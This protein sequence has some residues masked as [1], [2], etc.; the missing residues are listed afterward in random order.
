MDIQQLLNLKGAYI[1]HTDSD[2]DGKSGHVVVRDYA[3]DEM[4]TLP[5]MVATNAFFPTQ[6]HRRQILN[7]V[8]REEVIEFVLQQEL[9][10]HVA[11]TDKSNPSLPSIFWERPVKLLIGQI[12]RQI[13]GSADWQGVNILFESG[14]ELW[15]EQLATK[16]EPTAKIADLVGSK[17]I[18]AY[19]QPTFMNLEF[20]CGIALSVRARRPESSIC[21][22]SLNAGNWFI[23]EWG[24]EFDAE[25]FDENEDIE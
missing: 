2:I 8:R 11:I 16:P 14:W 17:I 7:V 6:L 22:A 4:V 5:K 20:S 21:S 19:D 13:E 15:F 24:S 23:V 12:V 1:N 3:N 10:F 9:W 18:Q 25:D